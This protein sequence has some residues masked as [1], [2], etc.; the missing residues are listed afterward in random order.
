MN[1]QF[2]NKVGIKAIGSRLRMLTEKITY[3]AAGIYKLYG[4]EMQPKWFPVF[5]SLSHGEEK[6][7]TG[8]A[9]E[10]G[11]SHP[12]VSKIVSEMIKSGIVIEKK[13]AADGRRNMVSLSERGIGYA[14]KIQDQYTDLEQ[15]IEAVN[16]QATHD[17]WKAIEE[18][19][20]LLEQKSLL[21]R[22]TEEKKHR[23]S[24][25]VQI[26]D[27]EPQYA[28]AF[29]SLNEEWISSY[30]KM[31][32]ADYRSLDDPEGYIMKKGGDIL[33]AL[34]QDQPVG[35]CAL[36]RM[37][38]GEYEFELAKM[39]VSPFAQGKNIG[40]LLGQ[41]ALD[42]ARKLG[43]KKIYLES[44]TILKPAINLYHKLGFQKVVGHSTPYERCNIQM[45]CDI[46]KRDN[47]RI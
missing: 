46:S 24:R 33:V 31:E 2:F 42:R 40:W 35:V 27:Y 4:I 20:F 13:D 34:Y 45:D 17:L 10:I 21:R 28:A 29:R 14:E 8:I 7:I 18:W 15:A 11:H 36:I 12:S 38:D 43:G 9:A 41:A 26:V 37:N 1:N 6:T 3:N 25:D 16:S 19:E 39:A 5:Y 30:F 47:N 32:E 23:E 22:V 44:N